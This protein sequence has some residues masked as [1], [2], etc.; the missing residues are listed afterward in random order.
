MPSPSCSDAMDSTGNLTRSPERE[1]P[2]DAATSARMKHD[3]ELFGDSEVV[4]RLAL[5]RHEAKKGY[6][7][8]Q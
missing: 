1:L 5:S 7:I 4:N 6:L 3:S 8:Q 2:S